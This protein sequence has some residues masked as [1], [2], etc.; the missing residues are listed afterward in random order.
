MSE[1]TF[2]EIAADLRA[3]IAEPNP[4]VKLQKI[5]AALSDFEAGG[6]ELIKRT[7]ADVEARLAAIAAAQD[8]ANAPLHRRRKV[9]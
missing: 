1:A 7:M 9:A 8:E 5:R 6:D 3:A 2:A 4:I